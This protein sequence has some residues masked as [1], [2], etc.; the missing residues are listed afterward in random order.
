LKRRPVEEAVGIDKDE[1]KELANDLWSL[2]DNFNDGDGSMQDD[3]DADC[4]G[5]DEE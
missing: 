5:E 3:N 1:L 2:H 4:F